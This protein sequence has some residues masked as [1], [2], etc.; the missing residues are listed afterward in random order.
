MESQRNHTV[1][2]IY[3]KE[4]EREIELPG[5]IPTVAVALLITALATLYIGIFPSNLLH[6]FQTAVQ[7][8]MY[9]QILDIF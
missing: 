5:T 3:M 9:I 4:P 6:L 1:V 8:V 2:F 7:E